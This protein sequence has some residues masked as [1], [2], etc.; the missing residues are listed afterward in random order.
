MRPNPVLRAWRE[1]RQTIGGWLTIGSSFSAEIMAHQGFDWLCID[2]QHGAIDY[3][4]CFHMLQAIS[5]TPTVPFVRVPSNDF[6]DIGRVLDAGAYGVIIPLVNNR[7]DA[8]RAVRAMRYPPKGERSSGPARAALYAGADYQ[9]H[10]NDEVACIVMIET[11]EAL[12]NLDAIMSVPGVDCAY[13][14]PSDLAYAL[15]LEPTGD[16]HDPRH[17]EAVLEILAAAKRHGV[18]P[19]MHT[20]SVEFTT[21][22]LEAG[23]QMV[24]LGADRAFMVRQAGAD[25]AAART[26]ANIE[27]VTA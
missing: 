7:W 6:A 8:E 21:R 15:G 17:S 27:R 23:F 20:A 25:L 11:V 1:G 4:D 26:A 24:M 16:N 2:M 18:A 22:W 3:P 9:A 14:G 13:I 12:H 5:T 10:A 19:G